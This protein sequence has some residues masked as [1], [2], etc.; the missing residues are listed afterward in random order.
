[1]IDA[2]VGGRVL[3]TDRTL[4]PFDVLID[5][6][7]IQGLVKTGAQT[8]TDSE[9]LDAAGG[10]V[11]AGFIDTHVHGGRGHNFMNLGDG[12]PSVAAHLA[13]AGVTS[14]LATTVTTGVASLAQSIEDLAAR[15]DLDGAV[16]LLGIHLEGPFLDAAHRGVHPAE[17]LR[18]PSQTE[19]DNLLHLADGRLRIATLAPEL[20]GAELAIRRL[21]EAGVTVS[22]GHSGISHDGAVLAF[23]TGVGRVTH[24]FNGL[25]P[26]HHRAPGPIVAALT[27]PSVHIEL[28]GDGEHVDP[29]VVRW[30]WQQIGT[31]RLVLVSD[32]V[33]V[34]GLPDGPH[35]R[36]EGTPV[37]LQDGVSRTPTGGLAGG[38]KG[39][40]R[41]V[42]DLVRAGALP[43]ADALCAASETPARSI[44]IEGVKGRILPGH[45]AD[46]V[47]LDSDLNLRATVHAGT[48]TYQHPESHVRIPK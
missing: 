40:A 14:C 20:P 38:T 2:I 32:G 15:T 45:D 42:R 27:N 37:L 5:R 3:M 23:Q 31:D 13:A 28:V 30:V 44:G 18:P 34:S 25:P 26:I 6:G 43:L 47:V 16:D 22:L 19:L 10:V 17:H 41:C 12:S 9:V 29:E 4:Q 1:M 46:L 8:F 21:V 36:W 39:L 24:C 11:S 35:H 48:L 7:R 33:D